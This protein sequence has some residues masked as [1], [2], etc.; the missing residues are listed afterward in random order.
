MKQVPMSY[1]N[2]NWMKQNLTTVVRGKSMYDEYMC[3]NCGIKGKS[4]KLGIIDIPER[5]KEKI[6]KC[7]G[8]QRT[9]QIK[10][11]HCKA[12]GA[13]FANLKDGSIHTIINPP[14]EYDNKRGEWVMGVGEPVLVL[15][16]EF[17]Y[18]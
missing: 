18:I 17:T 4:Y 7:K 10:V 8:L 5:Y 1:G 12:V 14:Y 9:K 15:T 16:N 6:A 11:T 3:S 2:H 13:Q